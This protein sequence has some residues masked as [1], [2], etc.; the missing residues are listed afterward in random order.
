MK[1]IWLVPNSQT[2]AGF[3]IGALRLVTGGHLL[4]L[5]HPTS[6]TAQT[7]SYGPKII[8]FKLE[9]GIDWSTAL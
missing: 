6:G 7:T 5:S 3:G 9:H 2:L 4:I 1:G 8:F